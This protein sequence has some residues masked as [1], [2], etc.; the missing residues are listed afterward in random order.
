MQYYVKYEEVKSHLGLM[1]S[2][3]WFLTFPFLPQFV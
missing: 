2:P 3:L 1:F